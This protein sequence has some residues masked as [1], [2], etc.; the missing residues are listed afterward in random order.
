MQADFLITDIDCNGEASGALAVALTGGQ[1]P[2]VYNWSNGATGSQIQDLPAG[3]YS[4]TVT[5]A[6]QCETVVSVTLQE[7]P[8][9]DANLQAL[10]I[11][12]AGGRDGRIEVQATGGTPAYSYSLD[13]SNFK[14]SGAFI[15]LT[16]GDYQVFVRDANGCTIT[17]EAVSI[18][19]PEPL[20]VSLGENINVEY[21]DT[22]L[23]DF[24]DITGGTGM[25][26]YSWSPSD[27][28]MLSCIDCPNP[29]VIVKEQT[30][31]KLLVR[32]EKGCT[33]DDII[34]I[35]VNKFNPVMVPTGFTPN[36]DGQNDLLHVHGKANGTRVVMFRI[37]DRWG[38]LLHEDG[39]F[40]L[41]DRSRGWDGTFRGQPL[42]GGVYIWHIEVEYPDGMRET[43]AGSTTLIR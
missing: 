35:F 37:Y 19:E 32:D 8:F 25:L 9:L 27:S 39:D 12:C 4:L 26:T 20:I 29:T 22:L 21:G 3:E 16:A 40:D 24:L 36:G 5:D 18:I 17:P 42:N 28:S 15:G 34:T 1:S 7:P 11:T 30:S 14:T 10:D 2:F 31:F 41:N 6:G 43:M 23:I 38:E 13:G 33:A